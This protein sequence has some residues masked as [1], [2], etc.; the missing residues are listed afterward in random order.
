MQKS[1]LRILLIL[2]LI[3]TPSLTL[4]QTQRVITLTDG[5]MLMGEIINFENNI[6]TVQTSNLGQVEIND[7]DVASISKDRP[8]PKQTQL[9]MQ[10]QGQFDYSDLNKLIPGAGV[11]GN[12]GAMDPSFSSQMQNVQQNILA[13]PEM[14]N[15]MEGLLQ[16]ESLKILLSDPE[17]MK[18][19]LSGDPNTMQ[20]NE[21]IQQLL[22]DPQ[23]QALMEKMRSRMPPPAGQ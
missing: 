18:S 7:A 14:M 19:V 15:D 2:T 9:Q 4:A 11:M 10:N 17:V 21:K 8:P 12:M 3:S 22:Q 1:I 6:Y 16:N 13:D 23:I 20:S 5:S